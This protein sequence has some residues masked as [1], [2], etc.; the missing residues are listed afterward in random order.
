MQKQFYSFH[1]KFNHKIDT[2][3]KKKQHSIFILLSGKKALESTPGVYFLW[4]VSEDASKMV[5][6]PNVLVSS[7]KL[8]FQKI[9][10]I[11]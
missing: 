11:L 1:I 2:L 3:E 4:K 7:I 6:N 10:Q 9:I 8:H 5:F